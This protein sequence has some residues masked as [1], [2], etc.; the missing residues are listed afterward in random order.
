MPSLGEVVSVVQKRTSFKFRQY[1]LVIISPWE[2]AWPYILANLKILF[3][4]QGYILLSLVEIGPVVLEKK[5]FQFRQCISAM[6]LLS[7]LGNG[8]GPSFEQ[9]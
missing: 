5:S 7:P 9:T 2:R 3:S 1:I 6:S 8:R 4:A